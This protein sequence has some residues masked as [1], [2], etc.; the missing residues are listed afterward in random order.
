M[1]YVPELGFRKYWRQDL[2]TL[3]S[4][5]HA[6]TN[7]Y[8]EAASVVQ[9]VH[10][11]ISDIETLAKCTPARVVESSQRRTIVNSAEENR[12]KFCKLLNGKPLFS[13]LCGMYTVTMKELQAVLKM[14][15]QARQNGAMNE[16]SLEST[17]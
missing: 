8:P 15:E 13:A 5:C 2:S 10:K 16:T 1:A 3:T 17:A 4:E 9:Q 14:N 7:K 11:V 6:T 12:A